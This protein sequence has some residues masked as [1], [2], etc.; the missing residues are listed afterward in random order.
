MAIVH[1]AVSDSRNDHAIT[2][3]ECGTPWPCA[4]EREF[5]KARLDAAPDPGVSVSR[6]EKK[7]VKAHLTEQ[8]VATKADADEVSLPTTGDKTE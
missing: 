6:A 2:C 7:F 8:T 4:P 1:Y 5:A 3:K